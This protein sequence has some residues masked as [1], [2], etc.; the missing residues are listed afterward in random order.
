[1]AS[2]ETVR[3][4]S[5]LTLIMAGGE[6]RGLSVLT[7]TRA[8]PAVTVAGKYRLVDFALSN[9]VNSGLHKVAVLTQYR[10]HSLMR[11]IG[12]GE[13][14]GLDRRPGGGVWIW[15]PHRDRHGGGWYR[16]TAD[17]LFQNLEAI[18]AARSDVLLILCG[19]HVYRQDYRDMLQFHRQAGADITV[20]VTPV[21]AEDTHRF[22]IVGVGADHRITEFTEKPRASPTRLA[23]MGVYAATTDFFLARL[24]EDARDSRSS[25]EIGGN[26]IPKMVERHR[27][28][29]YRFSGSWVDVGTVASYWS[30]NLRFLESD[31]PVDLHDEGWPL[32]TRAGDPPPAFCGPSADVRHSLLAPGCV[33]E[34]TVID[35]VLSPGVH[36]ERGAVVNKS[37]VLHGTA[38]RS[39]ARV[40]CS[41][42]DKAVE[43][44]AGARVGHRSE[45]GDL[46][47]RAS[48]VTL[49]GKGARVPA[50]AVLGRS[51]AVEP[52]AAPSDFAH[53]TI[54]SGS[55]VSRREGKR[56]M[57]SPKKGEDRF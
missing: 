45:E 42:A 37:V 18:E 19:D 4:P 39:D 34:G 10:P 25:H 27:A 31:P 17:A 36:I 1:M 57:G 24:E 12:S 56:S 7:G 49:L 41:V 5:V 29:A 13:P 11:H 50:G 54:P 48:G 55:I 46:D 33:V 52:Y 23:S 2:D 20:A 51:C 6:G 8:K 40:E 14:W 35:S 43:I 3:S 38:V 21:S 26:L 44:G 15:P 22:G 47:P 30:A 16:G 53:S 28:F 32:R 9:A